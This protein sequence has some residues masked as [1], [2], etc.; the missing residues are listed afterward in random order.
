MLIGVSLSWT[1]EL[2]HT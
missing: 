1:L 2:H